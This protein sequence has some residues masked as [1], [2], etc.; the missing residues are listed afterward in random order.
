MLDARLRD[1]RALTY[2]VHSWSRQ[3]AHGPTLSIATKVAHGDAGEAVAAAFDALDSVRSGAVPADRIAQLKVEAARNTVSRYQTGD[4]LLRLLR[5]L[6]TTTDD[7]D[8]GTFAGRLAAVTS[9][10]LADV[11]EPCAGHEVVSIVGDP[12]IVGPSLRASAVDFE[13]VDWR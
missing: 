7:D 8:D 3:T 12:E 9:E 2:G 4:E 10:S 6:A 1:E 11:L 5:D 13:V